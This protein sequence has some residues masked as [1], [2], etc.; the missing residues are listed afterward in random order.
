MRRD[1]DAP[2][3]IGGKV[4]RGYGFEDSFF[5]SGGGGIFLL[6]RLQ[7]WNLNQR[8]DLCGDGSLE[9]GRIGRA[10]GWLDLDLVGRGRGFCLGRQGEQCVLWNKLFHLSLGQQ[11]EQF[12]FLFYVYS[13]C[14]HA[15]KRVVA[16]GLDERFLFFLVYP[17]YIQAIEW[18]VAQYLF[19]GFPLAFSRH[20]G[21][22]LPDVCSRARRCCGANTR[23]WSDGG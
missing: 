5:Q 22:S 12:I 13:S 18:I 20:E 19:A 1:R 4:K 16:Q 8:F 6:Q 3:E 7:R 23:R 21:S 15:L 10:F 9:S 2:F 14:L 11:G 17:C